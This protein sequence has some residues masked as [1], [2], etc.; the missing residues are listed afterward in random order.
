MTVAELRGVLR[1]LPPDAVVFVD[2]LGA[3]EGVVVAAGVNVRPFTAL[4]VAN[5]DVIHPV[6]ANSGRTHPAVYIGQG[7]P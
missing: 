6:R 5:G 7:E 4:R 1:E 3:D 2:G